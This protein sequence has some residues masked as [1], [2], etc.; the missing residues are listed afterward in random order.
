MVGVLDSGVGGLSVW[1]E[2]VGTLPDEKYLYVADSGFCPYGPRDKSYIIERTS[3]I[4][5]FLIDRGADIIVV[6]C[7]TATA[8]AI[9]TLRRNYKIPFIGMEPATKPAVLH[10]ESGVIAVLATQGTFRGELYMGTLEKYAS[11]TR[12]I[13]IVG[14]N[15]V[16]LVEKMEWDTPEAERLVRSYVEPA[17]AEGAD[18]IVLGCT[19][20]PFLTKTIEKIAGSKVK[21]INPAPAIAKRAKEVLAGIVPRNVY[22]EDSDWFCT[23]AEDTSV[24]ASMVGMILSESRNNVF[25]KY[26]C[27]TIRL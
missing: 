2:L 11:Q 10:S 23:T 8:A 16:E 7:N 27:T 20:Y 3:R 5:E 6:A 14:N 25:R 17:I 18:H 26:K 24:L 13:E 9:S 22:S 1:R 12:V 19:H 15:L 21:I 4:S